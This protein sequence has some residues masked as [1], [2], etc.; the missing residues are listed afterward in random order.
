MVTLPDKVTHIKPELV[1]L[2]WE[3]AHGVRDRLAIADAR[4]DNERCIWFRVGWII[5]ETKHTVTLYPNLITWHSAPYKIAEVE[6]KL[7]IPKKS[8]LSRYVI[9]LPKK[10]LAYE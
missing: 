6:D 7:T 2:I 5:K 4:A 8:I 9:R 1:F 3:D 10:A